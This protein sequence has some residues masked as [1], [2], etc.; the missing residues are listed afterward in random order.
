[1]IVNVFQLFPV[2]NIFE[3]TFHSLSLS[4]SLEQNRSI[5]IFELRKFCLLF[6]SCAVRI[7]SCQRCV[8]SRIEV[9]NSMCWQLRSTISSFGFFSNFFAY[10][11][12]FCCLFSLSLFFFAWQCKPFSISS[13]ALNLS[14]IDGTTR[15]H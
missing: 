7:L 10:L 12:F 14:S 9:W 15:L 2:R 4:L 8:I 11:L 3:T 13:R 5:P 6:S 1:M